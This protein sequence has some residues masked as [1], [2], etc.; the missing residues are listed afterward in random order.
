MDHGFEQ[1]VGAVNA[2]GDVLVFVPE[3]NWRAYDEFTVFGDVVCLIDA[4]GEE[5]PRAYGPLT[6]EVARRT[7]VVLAQEI[8]ADGSLGASSVTEARHGR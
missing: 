6:V 7:G 1:G 4:E 5:F 3:E 2:R 8:R